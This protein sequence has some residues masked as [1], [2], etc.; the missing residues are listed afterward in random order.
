MCVKSMERNSYSVS[1]QSTQLLTTDKEGEEMP[2]LCKLLLIQVRLATVK[3]EL[4]AVEI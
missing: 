4:E 1:L 2:V 3:P